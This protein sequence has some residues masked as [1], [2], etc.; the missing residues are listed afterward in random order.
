MVT[1]HHAVN[2]SVRTSWSNLSHFQS[3]QTY[4]EPSGA[5]GCSICKQFQTQAW[6]ALW[7]FVSSCFNSQHFWVYIF[8][9]ISTGRSWR[10]KLLSTS[11]IFP[12]WQELPSFMPFVI[13]LIPWQLL[14]VQREH[15][16]GFRLVENYSGKA[17]PCE[18]NK[19]ILWLLQGQPSW[20]RQNFLHVIS[21]P[22]ARA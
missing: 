21:F 18:R 16:P 8:L 13:F 12:D 20:I 5:D 1:P 10:W 14:R 4:W 15:S 19:S 17:L 6:S 11:L 2:P 7:I 3:G 22:S 9:K